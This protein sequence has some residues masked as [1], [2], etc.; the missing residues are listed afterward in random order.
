M[1]SR[2]TLKDVAAVAGTSVATASRV[3][4]RYRE[5]DSPTSPS[6]SR[7][8]QAAQDL[9]YVANSAASSLRTKRSRLIGVVTPDLMD[10]AI[11]SMYAGLESAA[12]EAGYQT[13]VAN[14]RD[15]LSLRESR[16]NAF[17]SHGVDGIVFADAQ[18]DDEFLRSFASTGFPFVLINRPLADFPSVSCDDREGGRIAAAHLL[19]R[20]HSDA[21]VVTGPEYAPNVTLRAAGFV[22]Q[23]ELYGGNVELLRTPFAFDSAKTSVADHI[24]AN[25]A[26]TAVFSTTDSLAVAAAGALSCVGIKIGTD[27]ALVGFNDTFLSESAIIPITSIRHSVEGMGRAGFR[28]LEALLSGDKEQRPPSIFFEPSLVVRESSAR[29]VG[30]PRRLSS[31]GL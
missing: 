5:G 11:T 1:S 15:S 6:A 29:R 24:G 20:G 18:R 16:V 30:P 2:P 17:L 26:P 4:A 8:L 14:S 7:V 25:D 22:E 21:L 10:T 23:F 28:M 3:L 27:T 12:S 9:G 19:E 13:C 31:P